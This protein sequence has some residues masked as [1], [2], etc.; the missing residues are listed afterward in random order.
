M[1]QT[2]KIRKLDVPSTDGTH[3]L[4]GV[5]Y[6][7]DDPIAV[8]EIVHGMTEHI[9]RYDGF[10]RQLAEAGFAVV[11]YDQLGHG[12]TAL[13]E[14]ELGF[15][16][17]RDGDR[18]LT[19]DV[20]AVGHAAKELYPALPWI[21]LGHSMG[22]FI[23]RLAA[24]KI[25]AELAGLILIG[26]AGGNP[27]AGFGLFLCKMVRLFGGTRKR[28]AFLS[29]AAFF[30]YEKMT[31]KRTDFDWLTHDRKLI[32]QYVAD[33]LCGFRFTT[34]AMADLF[35]LLKRCNANAAFS[36]IPQKL[37]VLLLY[38]TE[39]PV[40]AYGAGPEKV[41]EN[42]CRTS[43]TDVIEVVCEGC[44]HEVLNDLNGAEW[45]ARILAWSREKAERAETTV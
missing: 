17:E 44:R 6:E 25:G 19:D 34:A 13:D 1:E 40:G 9:G 32:D 21:L 27:F 14:T 18:L 41:A 23:A 26:T 15:M 39:D 8:F 36:A 35:R 16:A 33:P 7:P 37:P 12:K 11:S 4:R 38:G 31:E 2:F 5:L 3:L 45:T 24:A 43:H 22:S 10:F 42:L 20:I 28:P 30:G 29:K